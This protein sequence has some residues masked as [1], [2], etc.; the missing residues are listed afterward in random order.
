MIQNVTLRPVRVVSPLSPRLAQE[1][2]AVPSA[3][4]VTPKPPFIDSALVNFT[5]DVFG[6][7]SMWTLTRAAVHRGSKMATVLGVMTG[8]LILKGIYDL[9]KVRER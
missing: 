6:A 5:V 1:T 3:V 8:G 2:T 7:A 9:S 4:V